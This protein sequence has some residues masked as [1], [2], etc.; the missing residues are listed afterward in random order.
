MPPRARELSLA[1]SLLLHG[2]GAVVVASLGLGAIL[3]ER[4]PSPEPVIESRFAEALPPQVTRLEPEVAAFVPPDDVE[5]E[6][7]VELAEPPDDVALE[8]LDAFDPAAE[9]TPVVPFG[10][11]IS[12][13]VATP[14][15]AEA[16]TVETAPSPSVTTAPAPLGAVNRPPEYPSA[17]RRRGF[18]GL[19]VVRAR[20]SKD[21]RCLGAWIIESTG[22]E[23]LDAAA[24]DAVRGWAFEPAR[25]GGERIEGE[26][27]LPIRFA[28][29]GGNEDRAG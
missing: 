25:R 28:L 23:I 24:L 9:A 17:A 21:G 18:E 15:P 4:R 27:D 7:L 11:E 20:V 8:P 3:A 5:I 26:I 19:A 12:W 1:A 16:E 13:K 10:R 29:T 2:G 14:P 22:C 6:P